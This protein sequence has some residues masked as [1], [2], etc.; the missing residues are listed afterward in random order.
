VRQNFLHVENWKSARVLLTLDAS[1]LEDFT[2]F[3]E[4]CGYETENIPKR[5]EIG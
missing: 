1:T 2:A 5:T 3:Q 4:A